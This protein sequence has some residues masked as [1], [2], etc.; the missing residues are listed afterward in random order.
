MAFL[1]SE[2]LWAENAFGVEGARVIAE[3]LDSN[4]TLTTLNLLCTDSVMR[5]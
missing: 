3:A 4:H 2:L 5:L 1:F